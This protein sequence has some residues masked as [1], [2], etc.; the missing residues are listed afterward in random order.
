MG[1]SSLWLVPMATTGLP[2]RRLSSLL[3]ASFSLLPSLGVSVPSVKA[4]ACSTP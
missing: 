2:V 1:P 3:E 4:S